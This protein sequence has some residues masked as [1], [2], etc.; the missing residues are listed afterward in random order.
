MDK[1]STSVEEYMSHVYNKL[2]EID[3]L[4]TFK[5]LEISS[6][7]LDDESFSHTQ[8]GGV[9]VYY[10]QWHINTLYAASAGEYFTE[11]LRILIDE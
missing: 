4:D 5:Y 11:Q 2:A 6:L 10:D 3:A 9:P 1:T 8:I 7:L